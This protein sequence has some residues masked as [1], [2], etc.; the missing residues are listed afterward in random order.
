VL[1][2]HE[3]FGLDRPVSLVPPRHS[4]PP[5]NILKEYGIEIVRSSRKRHPELQ[6][7]SNRVQLARD[8]LT[9]DQPIKQPRMVDD[10]IE[11][12]CASFP[13]LTAPF[14]QSGQKK[15]HPVFRTVPTTVRRRLHMHNLDQSLTAAIE[16]ES[17]VHIWTHLWETANE[18]QW[19]LIES[20]LRRV[21]EA[22]NTD[23]IQIKNMEKL[24]SELRR[25]L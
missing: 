7:A 4:P 21:T 20:F 16:Q 12:Y 11:T 6:E 22:I 5:R 8:I 15:P 10:V 19:P 23:Q 14:L 18:I 25:S 13:S 9:G 1:E 3:D 17:A 24:N 2:A